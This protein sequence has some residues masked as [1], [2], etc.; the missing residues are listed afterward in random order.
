MYIYKSEYSMV[1]NIN[2]RKISKLMS[3]KANVTLV[4]PC[5]HSMK[6]NVH[7]CILAITRPLFLPIYSVKYQV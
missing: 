5:V 6:R 7:A 2:G 1:H 4:E 3:Y